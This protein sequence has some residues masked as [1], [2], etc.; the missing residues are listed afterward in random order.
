MKKYFIVLVFTLLTL[1][2]NAQL[3]HYG[4]NYG[5]S[6]TN[7]NETDITSAYSNWKN[8]FT[9]SCGDNRIR[10]KFDAPYENQTVS[11]GIGY[12]MLAAAF[13]G[14]QEL[15]NGLWNYYNSFLNQNGVMNWKIEEC[16]NVLGF[17]G[18][19]DAELDVAM[20]LIIASKR[21]G[22][23]G[24]IKYEDDAKALIQII[25]EHEVE[26]N[27]YVLKPGDAWGGSS[28]TNISYFAPGYYRAYKEIT[29]DDFWD[30][31]AL[32]SYDIIEAN[33]NATGAVYNLVSDWCQANG[34]FSIEVDWA[35]NQGQKYD[36]D[37]SRTPWRIT[38]DYLWSGNTEALA[39]ANKCIEFIE[40]KNGLDNIYPGY[41][42]DGTPLDTSYKD[43]TFTGAYAISTMVSNNQ[44]SVND[45]YTKVVEMTTDAY[46]GATL[47]VLYLLTMSGNF[48][49]PEMFSEDIPVDE[50]DSDTGEDTDTSTDNQTDTETSNG[51]TKTDNQTDTETSNGDTQTDNQTDTDT[52]NGDTQT[53]NQ[54]DTETSN[55]DTQTDN[56]TD[57]ETSNG[58][59]QTDN[60]SDTETSNGDTQTDNQTDT[61]TSN[62][63]TQT[64]GESPNDSTG[65]VAKT[66]LYPNPTS[67]VLKIDF[68]E[69]IELISIYNSNGKL[70]ESHSNINN[71]FHSIDVKKLSRALYFIK[72]ND[73]N[74]KFIKK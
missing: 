8:T 45:A 30:N 56:Q 42:L 3:L 1:A 25:K 22:N 55:G 38:L 64:E 37:A 69:K 18:A 5:T 54:T 47:R 28:T 67:D 4:Y 21:W 16:S 46:F 23:E 31:V 40:S 48:Y 14:D 43:V 32:K 61:E 33:L 74:L 9:E 51:D 15:L 52:S 63:D 36:Y 26:N 59:T 60:Q 71:S 13:I 73:Y 34:N 39:Y 57:T 58:D 68:F 70:I 35:R 2:T 6:P 10:V 44:N 41:N 50:P 65:L 66:I 27:T 53:D 49:S 11:E 62:G 29:N 17:N 20:A 7:L 24:T 72:I 12:G 19:T